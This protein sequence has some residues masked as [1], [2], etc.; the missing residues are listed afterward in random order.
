MFGYGSPDG[1]RT[2][3]GGP[4]RFWAEEVRYRGGIVSG[5]FLY[6]HVV[7]AW[8]EGPLAASR[9]RSCLSGMD[10]ALAGLRVLD[11]S[12]SIAGQFCGRLLCDYGAEVALIEPNGGS[13]VRRLGPFSRHDGSS[14]LFWHLNTGK[15]SLA[16]D[17]ATEDGP[18]TLAALAS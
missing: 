6:E 14:L 13:A 5:V 18:R 3:T 17:L 9:E 8:R 4:S 10:S 1:W 2:A 7:E 12:E 11:M 16:I 15:R